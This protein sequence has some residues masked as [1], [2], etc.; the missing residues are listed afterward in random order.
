MDTTRQPAFV[1]YGL[2]GG[3]I[4]ALF[5]FLFFFLSGTATPQAVYSQINPIT[6]PTPISVAVPIED[7]VVLSVLPAEQSASDTETV[8]PTITSTVP[9][10]PATPTISYPA[11]TVV[12]PSAASV[13]QDSTPEAVTTSA[14]SPTPLPPVQAV[15]ALLTIP[16]IGLINSP[17][18]NVGVEKIKQAD[19]SS[20]LRWQARDSGVGYQPAGQGEICK[21]GLVTLN[22]HNWFRQ[23]PGVFI[24]LNKVK[25]GDPIRLVTD[26]GVSCDYQVEW[27][28]QYSPQETSWLYEASAISNPDR[29]Y[30]NIYTCSADFKERYV[31]RASMPKPI[32]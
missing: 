1:K 8:K 31:V 19:G 2:P 24:N 30:L 21:W 15:P 29:A 22:G 3:L 23:K 25:T 12:E 26:G 16:T 4:T 17:V 18:V 6:Q 27:S 9:T 10:I 13:S 32:T 11:T 28:R 7:I 14:P 20:V 5:L